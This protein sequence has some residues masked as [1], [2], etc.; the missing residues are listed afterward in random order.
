MA[1][2]AAEQ[3][4]D[5]QENQEDKPMTSLSARANPSRTGISD[6]QHAE[7]LADLR[8]L[9]EQARKRVAQAIDGG[10]VLLYWNVGTRIRREVLGQRRATY[11]GQIVATLS[12]QLALEY[13]RG[14]E[15]KNLRRM[16]LF[17]EQFPDD[18]IVATLS[19]QLSWSHF[20][21]LL[22][23]KEELRRQFYAE[24]CRIERWPVRTLKAKIQDMLYERTAIS[25][26]PALLAKAELEGL[27][28]ADRMTPDLV[29]RD[30]Y[31][32]DFLGLP[33]AF[34]E[35]DLES[36]LL[37]ELESFLLE[38]GTDFAF[39]SR[40]KR[41]TIDG[42]D[43]Y[44]DLLFFHRRLRRLVA[45]ELKIGEFQ[46]ADK[47]QMELYLR[48]LAKYE[49]AP[50]EDAPLGLILC[51]GKSSEHVE[52]LQ[53][54]QSGIR[55]AEYMLEVPPPDV[56]RAKLQ[57]MIQRAHERVAVVGP[58]TVEETILPLQKRLTKA[59]T[60]STAKPTKRTR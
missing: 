34:S 47:G 22:P 46:A 8:M 9:I 5:I 2:H 4:L 30:P 37:R 24:L 16:I 10:M 32:L 20:V 6:R 29:F 50:S 48:W 33:S 15:E 21:E 58:D 39:L 18:K 3:P 51:A 57:Q 11:G 26:R 42:R 28:N 19:R 43:Y 7:L 49:Q 55:V 54:E 40:Q 45:I 59:Q 12:R 13:G 44:I 36:A 38:L 53:L 60:T 31:R 17:S 41:L 23:L 1:F 14:F 52:L 56:L 27:R 25:R 35:K